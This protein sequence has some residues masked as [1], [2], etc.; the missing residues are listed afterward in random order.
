MA[1]EYVPGRGTLIEAV[2]KL[3]AA[4]TLEVHLGGA[5]DTPKISVR[6][7]WDVPAPTGERLT[8]TEE[9]WADDVDETIRRCVERQLVSDVPL[10]AFLSGGVDSSL[11]VAAMGD[12]QTFSIGFDDPTYNE[13]AWA[14]RV[15]DHLGVSHDFEV[16]QPTV[17]DLF[18]D[19]MNFMDDPIGDFSIFPT[20]LVSRHARRRVTVALSG[21]GGD[22]LFGGYETYLAQDKARLWQRIPRFLRSGMAEPA[23]RALR[24]TAKK[25]GLVNKAKRF[26]EGLEHPDALG[27]ARWRLFVGD[28]LRRS[29]FTQEAQSAM[30]TGS[31]RHILELRE[32]AAARDEVDRGLYVDFRSYL[33]D[34]CLV[35]VDRMSMACSL[36]TRVP[37]L[38]KELVELAFRVPSRLKVSG[39]ETKDLLKRV[40]ARHVP[41]ECVY[42]P[43]E[44]FSIPIKHWLRTEFRP[45]LE[46]LLSPSRLTRDGVFDPVTAER[47]KAEHLSGEA[48]HSHVLWS[49]LVFQDWRTRWGV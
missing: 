48:N 33:V 9:A 23:I 26:V 27:H 32:D 42:R 18:D 17:V 40:A 14:Q 28:S 16:I 22:E 38:D 29:L 10:G 7:F 20:Y 2:R 3:E 49:M 13:L 37:L 45:A 25:K 46:E 4:H 31:E 39:S 47:L 44:G 30:A 24:P 12:A 5:G 15:A 41:R 43:K 34:N 6:R 36:E 8:R 35:K 21:D 1:W 19:L 11:V